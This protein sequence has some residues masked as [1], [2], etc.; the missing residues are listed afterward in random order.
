M[1]HR[2]RR[3]QLNRFTSWRKSTLISLARN[4]IINQ[5]IITT[6]TKAKAASR[7]AERL[8]SLAR[9]GSLSAARSAYKILGDHK[10]VRLLFKDIAPRFSKRS[11]GF[12]RILPW[13]A[14]RG[15][16]ADM[17]IFE[18][19]EIKEKPKKIKKETKAEPKEKPKEKPAELEERPPIEKKPSKKFLG[20]LRSIFKK[21]RDSL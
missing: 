9:D 2:K 15:D 6:R 17:V 12:T 8:I 16:N 7:L 11:S 4:L 14:R 21:E 20:G 1:R 10:L 13:R 18:F 19:T 5:R 3:L